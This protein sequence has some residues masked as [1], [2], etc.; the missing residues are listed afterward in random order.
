MILTNLKI[1]RI[2]KPTPEFFKQYIAADRRPV[3]I[4]GV[5]NNWQAYSAWTADYLNNAIG[6][7]E[8][9]VSVSQDENFNGLMTTKKQL[10]FRDYLDSLQPN[11]NSNSENYYL[12]AILIPKTLPIL[13]QDI[14]YPDYFDRELFGEL[15]IWLGRS[16][17]ITPLHYDLADNLFAQVRGR[18]RF[19][20]FD[21]GQTSLLYLPA[22]DSITPHFSQV[23]N[24]DEV[25]IT[26]FPKFKKAQISCEC[27]LE[28][29]E[30]LFIPGFWWHQVYS[31][32]NQQFPAISVNF[33]WT[34]PL[35]EWITTSVGRRF[36]QRLPYIL[37]NK[38]WLLLSPYWR[39]K[40]KILRKLNHKLKF[41]R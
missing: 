25:D 8:V 6:D 41:D 32:D 14:E 21:P 9:K 30:M 27:T 18:K 20:F 26:K 24:I 13:L 7:T 1:E 33:W 40:L 12:Q 11:D 23:G 36:L 4:T 35:R 3:I 19:V 10:K 15:N 16:G 34:S 39:R 29:G 28:P 31:L 37:Q 17:K 2:K 22:I 5:V 38:D